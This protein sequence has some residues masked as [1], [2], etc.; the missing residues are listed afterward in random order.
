M[1]TSGVGPT[2]S[3]LITDEWLLEVLITSQSCDYPQTYVDTFDITPNSPVAELPVTLW[4]LHCSSMS[5]MPFDP[6]H[7]DFAGNY[8]P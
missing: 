1:T 7:W 8:I 5:E 4:D 2:Y 3:N 6:A